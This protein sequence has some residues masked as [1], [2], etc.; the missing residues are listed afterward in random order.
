MYFTKRLTDFW[1]VVRVSSTLF[2]EDNVS[3]VSVSPRET[4]PFIFALATGDYLLPCLQRETSPEFN[5]LEQGCKK[6]V[7]LTNGFRSLKFCYVF[8][9][10]ICCSSCIFIAF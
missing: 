3:V 5:I 2:R 7:F 6:I 4:A 1:G 8:Q 10:V 9:R